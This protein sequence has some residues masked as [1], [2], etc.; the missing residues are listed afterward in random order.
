MSWSRRAL[1]GLPLLPLI[2]AC[3]FH[4]LY[5]ESQQEVLDPDLAA[6]IVLPIADR[7]GQKL[8]F[9]LREELNPDGLSVKRRY[10]LQVIMRASRVD[11]GLQ[12]DATSI[13]GRI[14]VSATMN[15][16][17]IDTHKPVYTSTAVSSSDFTILEDAYAAQVGEDDARERTVRDLANQ[18]RLR[19]SLFLRQQ[20]D[21]RVAD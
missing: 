1:L 11:L 21:A 5:S 2:A 20:H 7:D 4:P 3:G 17:T 19:L 10:V 18:I 14:D 12:R 13:R 8:E 9:M 16:S 15:L 6:I